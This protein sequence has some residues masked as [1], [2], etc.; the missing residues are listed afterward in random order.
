MPYK[1]KEVA[2]ISGV[3]VRT[4][5]HYDNIGLLK[6]NFLSEKGYRLYNQESIEKLQQ[7][8]FF[9]ELDFSL[10][11]IKSILNNP[12]FDKKKAL[13]S[14]KEL[15]LKK[16]KRLDKIIKSVE[17]TI[18]SINGGHKMTNKDVFKAF[19]MKE[20]VEHKEK[21]AEE[22]KQKWGHTDAYKESEKKVSKY[23]KEDW[24]R[25]NNKN[26]EVYKIIIDNMYKGSS[27]P[28][29]QEA[30]G[31]LRQ[32]ITD[33]FYNCTKE[34]FAGLGEMYVDDE[35]FRAFYENIAPNKNLAEFLRDAI[36]I[37]TK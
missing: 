34:I 23:T 6:P 26:A 29:I 18:Y 1:I 31:A 2:D 27:N 33:N 17:E 37:Y 20:I 14:H 9:K 30:I 25:I 15:L 24:E 28:I 36:R 12:N 19:Q 13:E 22:V 21:Y 3:T 7:I 35:R 16:R 11:E 5:Q 32:N 8:L 10:D 4:L